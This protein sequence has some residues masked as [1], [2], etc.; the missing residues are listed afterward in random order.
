MRIIPQFS[1]DVLARLFVDKDKQL[2]LATWPLY[3]ETP[4]DHMQKEV[5]LE[6]VEEIHFHLYAPPAREKKDAVVTPKVDPDK[7]EPK[8]D[9]W[10]QNQWHR[11]YNQMP[12]IIRIVVD[13]KTKDEKVEKWIFAFVLPSSKNPI[14]YPETGGSE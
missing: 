9:L 11:T 1:A 7:T 6:N 12:S 13:V 10:H 2:C 5:L 3:G 8:R 4:F 14:I